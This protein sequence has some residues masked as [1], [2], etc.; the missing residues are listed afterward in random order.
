[1]IALLRVLVSV[2][3]LTG[4]RGRLGSWVLRPDERTRRKGQTQAAPQGAGVLAPG[5]H[6][7]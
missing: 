3:L 1:M 2:R 7:S 5:L 4:C 6:P